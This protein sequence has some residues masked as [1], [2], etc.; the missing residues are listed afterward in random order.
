MSSAEATRKQLKIKSGVVKRY[1]KELALYNAEVVEH[2]KKLESVTAADV[3]SGDSKES[4][5]VRNAKSLIRESENMVRDTATRLEGAAHELG[6]LVKLAKGNAELD[7][8]T[9]LRNAEE[10]LAAATS[11]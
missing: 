3:G 10:V 6:D 4:W 2:K 7:K 1:H 9:E 11:A 8:D 5:D